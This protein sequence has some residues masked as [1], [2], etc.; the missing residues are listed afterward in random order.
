MSARCLLMTIPRIAIA[1]SLM[2]LPAA[3]ALAAE[4]P[5]DVHIV[6]DVLYGGS[7]FRVGRAEQHW[8][9]AG[10]RY[11]LKTDLVPMLGPRIHYLSKGRF[12]EA[13]L[14]PESFAEYRGSETTPRVQADF[15]WDKLRLRYGEPAQPRTA[16]LERGAQDVNALAFQLAWLGDKAAGS[17]QVT[18]GKKVS[19]R[20]FAG[21]ARQRVTV[22]GKPVEA[23]PWRS[24]E[25]R[26]RTEVWVAASLGN[27]PVRVVRVDDDKELQLVAREL[28]FST[29]PP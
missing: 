5:A 29:S 25:G 21:S 24:G 14:V 4:L 26:D 12:T 1:L 20:S 27:L 6:Y 8:H 17:L 3:P 28:K 18:T 23:Q 7:Q 9:L 13:G 2:A 19:Q 10:G 11:E 15:D 22:N 16:T